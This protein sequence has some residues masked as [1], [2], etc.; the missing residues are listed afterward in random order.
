MDLA[1][2]T[3]SI[4]LQFVDAPGEL[5]RVRQTLNREL[6]HGGVSDRTRYAVEMVV[7]EWLTNVV[8][9]GYGVGSGGQV[10]IRMSI[11]ESDVELQFDDRAGAFD[12][13]AQAEPVVPASIDEARPGG[14]GLALI[15]RYTRRLDHARVGGGNRL[16]ATV[17]RR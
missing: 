2:V 17:P 14:L 1:A 15:R 8:R 4:E 11:G 9:H 6:T 10:C 3:P 7:E 12:P 13:R 5:E 16:T